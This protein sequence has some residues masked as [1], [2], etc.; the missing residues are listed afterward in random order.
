EE[1]CHHSLVLKKEDEPHAEVLGYKV[2]SKADLEV[3]AHLFEQKGHRMKWLEKGQ[4]HAVGRALR[5]QDNS[6]MPLEFFADMDPAERMLQRYDM[7]KGARVQRI[8]HFNCMVPDV[9]ESHH[10]YRE[11]L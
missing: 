2:A 11:K 3:L 1:H 10:F 6:G 8:D 5:V 7:Y 4:Q 9:E